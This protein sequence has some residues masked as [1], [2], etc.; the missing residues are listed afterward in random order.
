MN[1]ATL[2]TGSEL[3]TSITFGVRIRPATGAMSRTKLNGRFLYSVAFIPF[4][5]LTSSQVYPSGGDF[6]TYS[7]PMLLPPPGLFS[8]STGWPRCSES[9]LAM[10][11]ASTSVVPAGG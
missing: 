1:S 6:T 9:Q 8:I 10:M 5:G 3:V 2:F 11:R 7:T 4:A